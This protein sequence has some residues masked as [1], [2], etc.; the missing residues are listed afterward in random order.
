MR[1]T[2]AGWPRAIPTISM[3]IQNPPSKPLSTVEMDDIY[4][5]PYTRTWHP[6][7]DEKG[8]VPAFSEVRFSLIS[9]RGCFGAC[10]SPGAQ[11]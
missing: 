10:I 5:L 6:D 7:Y 8:G 11:P 4:D 2:A 9:N 1:S 3:G